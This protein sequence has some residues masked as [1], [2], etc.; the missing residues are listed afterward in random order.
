MTTSYFKQLNELFGTFN[1][2]VLNKL[3]KNIIQDSN[4][5]VHTT[6][7]KHITALHASTFT[8]STT[9]ITTTPTPAT[10]ISVTINS[11]ASTPI[12]TPVSTASSTPASTPAETP[13]STPQATPTASKKSGYGKYSTERRKIL[14]KD[15]PDKDKKEIAKQIREEWKKMSAADKK[16]YKDSN[17]LNPKKKRKPNVWIF[18]RSQT[19]QELKTKHPTKNKNEIL[20]LQQEGWK[21]CNKEEKADWSKKMN[22]HFKSKEAKNVSFD[23]KV[24]IIPV[25]KVEVKEPPIPVVKEGD[26]KDFVDNAKLITEESKRIDLY[27]PHLSDEIINKI[28]YKIKN[29]EGISFRGPGGNCNDR[30]RRKQRILNTVTF[31]YKSFTEDYKGSVTYLN[32]RG[33]DP[34]CKITPTLIESV[35][36][37][38]SEFNITY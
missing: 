14:K 25:E 32:A 22:A 31:D 20:R 19:L 11:P 17:P 15:F 38:L 24:S 6:I 18:Y 36:F 3:F 1:G 2:A 34:K 33:F 5:D 37:I 8:K 16:K 4:P 35:K 13:V 28:Y 30:E 27:D 9:T 10:S 7:K 29:I 23:N 26:S 12:E 21:K